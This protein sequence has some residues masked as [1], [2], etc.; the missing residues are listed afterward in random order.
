ML[1]KYIIDDNIALQ[2]NA[3]Q[4][5]LDNNEDEKQNSN[6]E[7]PNEQRDTKVVPKQTNYIEI[8]SPSQNASLSVKSCLLY[9]SDAA[10]DMQCVYLG[11][12]HITKK[13]KKIYQR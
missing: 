8:M 10:D 12:R 7:I 2:D 13:K 6:L 4:D 3:K 5:Y 11:G 1:K 9:T